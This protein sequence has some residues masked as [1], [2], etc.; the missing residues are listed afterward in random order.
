MDEL[1]FI[2]LSMLLGAAGM[3]LLIRWL[4]A[5]RLLMTLLFLTGAAFSAL[6][7][8]ILCWPAFAYIWSTG[9]YDSLFPPAIPVHWLWIA[10]ATGLVTWSVFFWR[11]FGPQRQ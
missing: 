5:Y 7:G 2:Y 9:A 1:A 8:I 3:I 6:S 4:T 10:A 11:S